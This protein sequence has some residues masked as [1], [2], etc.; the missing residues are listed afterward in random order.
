MY[1]AFNLKLHSLLRQPFV[2]FHIDVYITGHRKTLP[3]A[4]NESIVFHSGR[5]NIIQLMGGLKQQYFDIDVGVGVC[6]YEQMTKTVDSLV[7]SS[8]FS[9]QN[10]RWWIKKELF[11][12]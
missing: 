9:D 7:H 8:K 3:S 6:A 10:T 12:I 1:E 2:S 11:R 4:L 5:P